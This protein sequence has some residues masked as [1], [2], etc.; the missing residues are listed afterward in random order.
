LSAAQPNYAHTTLFGRLTASDL[1][2]WLAHRY[3][4]AREISGTKMH[5]GSLSSLLS[6]V[7]GDSPVS[8][9]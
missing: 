2:V 8:E 6:S 9:E 3:D 7:V 1:P 5:S 4:F